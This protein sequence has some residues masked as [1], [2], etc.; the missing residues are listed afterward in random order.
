M[1]EARRFREVCQEVLF[2]LDREG[3]AH[4]P[5]VPLGA[6]LE[7]PA[8]ALLADHFSVI[9]DFLSIGT[10]DLIQYSLADDRNNE[11]VA[12]LYE[13]LHPSVLRLL[14]TIAKNVDPGACELS[15]CGE[16]AADPVLTPFLLGLGLR[17]L[18]MSP[19][20]IPIIKERVRS[21]EIPGLDQTVRDC[22]ALGRAQDVRQL[23][24]E[25]YPIGDGPEVPEP[26]ERA[27][28]GNVSRA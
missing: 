15:I 21:L 25:R 5:T 10:N 4:D 12:D 26:D 6:M 16:M 24:V 8:A 18:S 17:R 9:F 7:V 13:S 19:R 3:V 11:H 28:A 1:E 2:D 20:S 27:S 22:L 23:L 14:E